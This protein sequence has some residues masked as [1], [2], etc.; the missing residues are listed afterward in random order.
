MNTFF[1]PQLKEGLWRSRQYLDFISYQPCAR[2]GQ[3]NPDGRNDPH[4]ERALGGG[5]TA[6]KPPDSYAVPLTHDC[7]VLRDMWKGPVFYEDF[8]AVREYALS[9]P[10]Y[11]AHVDVKM[12][13]IKYLTEFLMEKHHGMQKK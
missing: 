3:M 6:L 9:E 8:I 5:G 12:L 2:C 4:H 13:I 10:F 1:N 7:H 11:P